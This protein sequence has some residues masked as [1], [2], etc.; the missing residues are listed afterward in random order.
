MPLNDPYGFQRLDEAFL[1]AEVPPPAQSTFEKRYQAV[2][3]KRVAP[4]RP[5]EYQSQPNKRGAECRIY[6]NSHV[7]A[8]SAK[9]LGLKV[10]TGHPYKSK[11]AYRI[12]NNV[13]WWELVEQ[14]Q[15]RLGA[16]P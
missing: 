6:F 5:S 12:N 11:Y 4:G 13:L 3:K 2:T 7:V 16:N 1:E 8:A 10:K 15:F 14:F 9:T